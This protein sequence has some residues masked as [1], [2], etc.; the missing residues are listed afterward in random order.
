[1][2][3]RYPDIKQAIV[4]HRPETTQAN[5]ERSPAEEIRDHII[6]QAYDFFTEQPLKTVN[7]LIFR[8][9]LHDWPDSH[10]IQVLL[11]QIPALKRTSKMLINDIY[12]DR[13]SANKFID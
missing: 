5:L 13:P 8:T 12:V 2:L 9:V 1:M 6:Y 4:Q 3:I 11:N 7:V 10:A